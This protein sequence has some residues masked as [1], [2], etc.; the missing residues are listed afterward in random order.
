M[1]SIYQIQRTNLVL[2]KTIKETC[3]AIL[4]NEFD[5]VLNNAGYIVFER[6]IKK[7]MQ[8]YVLEILEET[9]KTIVS[10]NI[11]CSYRNPVRPL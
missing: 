9:I 5:L 1:F 11:Y 8:D 2:L 3:E 6:N 10:A 4:Y 7:L